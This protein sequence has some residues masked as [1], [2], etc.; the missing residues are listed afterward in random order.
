[1]NLKE[2][3]NPPRVTFRRIHGRIVPIIQGKKARGASKL[4]HQEL[5]DRAAEISHAEKG[6]R[7]VGYHENVAVKNFGTRST[8]PAWYSEIGFKGKSD[9]QKTLKAKKGIKYDRL[10]EDSIEGLLHGRDSSFGKIPP[11]TSFRLAT[12]QSFDN[13]NVIFRKIDGRVVPLR[14]KREEVPF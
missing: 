12:K 14:I 3:Q 9:F 2:N 7:G 4:L 8:F 5:K 6:V 13:T 11:S 1:M 10:V